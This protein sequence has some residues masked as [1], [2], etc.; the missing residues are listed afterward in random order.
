MSLTMRPVSSSRTGVVL[1]TGMPDEYK[2]VGLPAGQHAWIKRD[3]D[4]WN[5]LRASEGK[6]A[7]WGGNYNTAEDALRSLEKGDDE[8]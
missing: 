5:I 8:R 1:P 6:P 4:H 7:K 2:V 3:G